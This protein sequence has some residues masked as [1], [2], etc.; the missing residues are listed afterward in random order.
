[1]GRKEGALIGSSVLVFPAHSSLGPLL[2]SPGFLPGGGHFLYLLTFT[3]TPHHDGCG[4]ARRPP[5][6]NG[7]RGIE[8]PKRRRRSSLPFSLLLLSFIS[9]PYTNGKSSYNHISLYLYN[10]HRRRLCRA[11]VVTQETETSLR[12]SPAA[13]ISSPP[14]PPPPPPP[15]LTPLPPPPLLFRPSLS[16]ASGQTKVRPDIDRA[17]GSAKECIYL[18]PPSLPP[19]P[20]PPT[21]PPF[22]Q[23]LSTLS[24]LSLYMTGL[25]PR[26]GDIV[27]CRVT[28]VAPRAAHVDIQCVGSRALRDGAFQGVIRQEHV[29]A[30]GESAY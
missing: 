28:R 12:P 3:N 20:P 25:V 6:L 18:I 4:N 22:H 24:L 13:A 27:I 15:P 1:M 17:T 2:F 7:T 16:S 21:P 26:I 14:P 8:Q 5:L 29:R 23:P 11:T 10:V 19:P 30:T 9:L